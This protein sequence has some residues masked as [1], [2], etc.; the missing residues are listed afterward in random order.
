MI[1]DFR[2]TMKR[3]FGPTYNPRLDRDRLFT[4]MAAV[5]DFM[6]GCQGWRT[7][8]EMCAILEDRY[9]GERFPQASVSAQLRHLRKRPFGSYI[10]NKRRRFRGLWEYQ[11]LPRPPVLVEQ[12]ELPISLEVGT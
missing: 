8:Y 7:L 4:Q 11:V 1:C 3:T 9:P 6:L 2:L 5:R 10:V 12:I